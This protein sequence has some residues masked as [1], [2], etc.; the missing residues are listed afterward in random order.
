MNLR[1]TINSI[2]TGCCLLL[3]TASCEGVMGGLYD[4]NSDDSNTVAATAGT[5]YMDATDWTK[6][7]YVDFD[8]LATIAANGDAEALQKAQTTFMGYAIPDSTATERNAADSLHQPGIYTYWFDV[9]DKGISNNKFSSFRPTAPQ[10]APASWTIAIHRDN[11]RTNGGAAYE[12]DL[13]DFSRIPDRATQ[14]LD[15]LSAAGNQLSWTADTWSEND[16]W[17]DRSRMLS[18]YIGS[19]GIAINQV[20]SSW[21]TFHIP[22]IPPSATSNNHIFLLRTKEGKY[23]ALQLVNYMNSQGTK[24]WMTIRYKCMQ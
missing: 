13:T 4:K 8:S 2:L 24:C 20:L 18:E 6:W 16:V 5:L 7:Y 21:M 19:Q 9:F 3:L 15:S 11:V 14:L 17:Y 22:P 1:T 23:I 12:T 10:S